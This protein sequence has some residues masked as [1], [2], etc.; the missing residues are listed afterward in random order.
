MREEEVEVADCV[1]YY[2]RRWPAGDMV[3][4]IHICLKGVE[5]GHDCALFFVHHNNFLFLSM[6][7][8]LPPSTR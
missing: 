2:V 6:R 8:S 7:C 3:P 5:W 1:C 4:F